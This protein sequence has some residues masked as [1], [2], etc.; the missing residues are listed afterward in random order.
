MASLEGV[1]QVSV[2]GISDR[3]LTYLATAAI[4]KKK[5]FDLTEQMVIDHVANHFPFHKHLHGG[6][7]FMDSLP[8]TASGKVMK[9]LI[10][11]KLITKE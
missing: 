2:L 9:R 8:M 4:V 3:E 11:D 10:R 1:A 7:V 6:V 5:N